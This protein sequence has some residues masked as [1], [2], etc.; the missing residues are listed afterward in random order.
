MPNTFALEALFSALSILLTFVFLF[1]LAVI[2]TDLPTKDLF[3]SKSKLSTNYLSIPSFATYF[4]AKS[5]NAYV[6]QPSFILIRKPVTPWSDFNITFN[7][8][9]TSSYKSFSSIPVINSFFPSAT[10]PVGWLMGLWLLY[11]FEELFLFDSDL[12]LLIS[13][14]ILFFY[15]NLAIILSSF[16]IF[17]SSRIKF[18][19]SVLVN[20]LKALPSSELT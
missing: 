19:R 18:L 20:L 3:F 11:S 14:F 8:D 13:D 2:N 4:D 15:F 10:S 1:I 6:E 12:Y 16:S 9:F 7:S 5:T 17:F